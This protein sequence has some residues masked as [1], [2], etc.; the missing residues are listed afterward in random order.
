MT[1]EA[2]SQNVFEKGTPVLM[3]ASVPQPMFEIWVQLVAARSGQQVDWSQ[4]AGRQAVKALGDIPKARAMLDQLRP[5]L[6]AVMVRLDVNLQW[7]P[8]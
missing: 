3:V 5:E 6:E 8:L 4:Y 1:E 7:I 2:C